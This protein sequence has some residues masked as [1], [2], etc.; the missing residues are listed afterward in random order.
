MKISTPSVNPVSPTYILAQNNPV[1]NTLSSNPLS[2]TLPDK[3]YAA[4]NH[5]GTIPCD[6]FEK[7]QSNISFKGLDTEE[8]GYSAFRGFIG[9]LLIDAIVDSFVNGI[10]EQIHKEQEREG[11][12]DLL[13]KLH[14]IKE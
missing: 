4:K 12:A 13:L 2:G 14:S 8:E 11:T 5:L 6:T 7:S 1:K 10:L 3:F 9:D